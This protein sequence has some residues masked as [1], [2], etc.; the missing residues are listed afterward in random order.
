M[1]RKLIKPALALGFLFASNMA[2]WALPLPSSPQFKSSTVIVPVADGC[3]GGRY[4]GP[5]GACHRFGTGPFPRGY[6]GPARD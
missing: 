4:R 5:E 2:V 6:S 3:G 1:P